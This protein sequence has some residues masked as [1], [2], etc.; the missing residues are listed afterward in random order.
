MVIV[1]KEPKF[2]IS[3]KD[4]ETNKVKVFT[5]YKDGFNMDMEKFKKTLELLCR[6][7]EYESV[8]K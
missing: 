1:G 3:I 2:R 8:K 4:I 5:V 6:K 7:I